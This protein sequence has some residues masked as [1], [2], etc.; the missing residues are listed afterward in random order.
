MAAPIFRRFT[1]AA[2]AALDVFAFCTDDVSALT[3]YQLAGPNALLDLVND[4]DPAA[5]LRYQVSLF[6]NSLDTGRSWFSNSLSAAS[7]GRVAVGPVDIKG[8]SQIQLNVAQRAGAL[9]AQSFVVKLAR[10]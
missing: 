10:P 7:A 2:P 3:F 8:P 6:R 5:G 1:R 9:T 4:P